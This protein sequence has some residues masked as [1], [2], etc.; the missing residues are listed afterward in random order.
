[1]DSL[2]R[3]RFI[4]TDGSNLFETAKRHYR[5][6]QDTQVYLPDRIREDPDFVRVVEQSGGAG[7]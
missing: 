5:N 6:V 3:R 2:K 1:M 7:K 4:D